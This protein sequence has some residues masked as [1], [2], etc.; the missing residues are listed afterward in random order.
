MSNPLLAVVDAFEHD[1][2]AM[3][4]FAF[5]MSCALNQ[6]EQMPSGDEFYAMFS[7]IIAKLTEDKDKLKGLVVG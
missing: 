2:S 1:L 3:R 6:D 5:A 7:M 4:G